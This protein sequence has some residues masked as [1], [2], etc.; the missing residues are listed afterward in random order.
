[1]AVKKAFGWT[2]LGSYSPSSEQTLSQTAMVGNMAATTSSDDLLKRFWETEE[3]T[4]PSA[5]TTPE[6]QLVVTHFQH[7]HLYLK[8][9]RYQVSL[10]KKSDPPSLGESRSQ[11][12]RRFMANE[13]SIFRKGS[14][15]TF[16]D[17]V[18]EYITHNHA[19][20]VPAFELNKPPDF[21]LIIC[22]CMLSSRTAVQQLSYALPSTHQPRPA[23][24]TC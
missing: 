1:M 3:L 18:K 17:V 5:C 15:K 8:A 12:L 23:A 2:V 20:V 13:H 6:E 21:L 16:Q 19:E 10:P 14:W 9:G 22:Q 4:E 24:G 7:N 11:A